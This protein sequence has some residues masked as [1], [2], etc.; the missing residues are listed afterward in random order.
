MLDPVP[1]KFFL[2]SILFHH[3]PVLDMINF[4]LN[5]NEIQG[6]PR[7]PAEPGVWAA[8]AAHQWPNVFLHWKFLKVKN[9]W[10]C[11]S[12]HHNLEI[13]VTEVKGQIQVKRTVRWRFNIQRPN[14]CKMMNK[15]NLLVYWCSIPH[16]QFNAS[17][18][19][20]A[21][22]YSHCDRWIKNP[23]E[24][25]QTSSFTWGSQHKAT[26][27][28]NFKID[29]PITILFLEV[30]MYFINQSRPKLWSFSTQA[31]S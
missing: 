29:I 15:L 6:F 21:C 27:G 14:T 2:K 20:L 10:R 16:A 9:I 22:L 13:I 25:Q 3:C 30:A 19:N 8:L 24:N 1:T 23:N 17:T 7:R 31:P 26:I 28:G 18:T 11:L 5:S 4:S 12:R